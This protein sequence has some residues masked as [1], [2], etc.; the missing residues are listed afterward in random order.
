[1]PTPLVTAPLSHP[2]YT[3]HHSISLTPVSPTSLVI[4]PLSHQPHPPTSQHIPLI[5]CSFYSQILPSTISSTPSCHS[6]SL[7]STLFFTYHLPH[8]HLTNFPGHR[9]SLP[10]TVFPTSQHLLKPISY[11]L[12]VISFHLPSLSFPQLHHFIGHLTRIPPWP[13]HLAQPPLTT[14]FFPGHFTLQSQHIPSWPPRPQLTMHPSLPTSVPNRN[15]FL[16]NNL[17]STHSNSSLHP[18]FTLSSK[19]IPDSHHSITITT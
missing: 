19:Y 15:V 1:M 17:P 12:L 5:Q 14:F 18:S 10:S 16:P 9:T 11:I 8:F 7:L 3:L 2:P 4:G 6:A 13:T